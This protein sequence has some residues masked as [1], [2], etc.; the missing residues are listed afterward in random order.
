[1]NSEL[2]VV[3]LNEDSEFKNVEDGNVDD[4]HALALFLH[5]KECSFIDFSNMF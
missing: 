1:M 3:Q 5:C 2:T 4:P